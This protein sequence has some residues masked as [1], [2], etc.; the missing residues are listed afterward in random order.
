LRWS[1]HLVQL[2]LREPVGLGT[3]LS[4]RGRLFLAVVFLG[5]EV[6]EVVHQLSPLAG[7]A[8][9]P[10]QSRPNDQDQG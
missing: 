8:P 2:G 10:Q 9:E 7:V 6:G 1:A 4:G 5:E 3:P